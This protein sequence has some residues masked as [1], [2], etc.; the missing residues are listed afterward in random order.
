MNDNTRADVWRR[1]NASMKNLSKIENRIKNKSSQVENLSQRV[2]ELKEQIIHLTRI[3]EKIRGDLCWYFS[4]VETDNISR[5]R[6][7]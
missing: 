3:Q 5:A 4:M 7:Q 1:I 6:Q 2:E